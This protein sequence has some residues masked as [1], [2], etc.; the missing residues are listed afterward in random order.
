MH[1]VT[2]TGTAAGAAAFDAEFRRLFE[3]RF[4]SLFRYLDRLSG[5]AALAEDV[6]QQAF[7]KLYERGRMPDDP[8]AWLA[9][10][11]NNLFRDSR[12]GTSRRLR[13][14]SGRS[15]DFA[16]ADP[17][18]APDAGVDAPA[19]RQAARRALDGL[20]E[21]ERRMLLLR[22]E[23]YSY[24]EIAAALELAEASVGSLLLRARR[25]FKSAM[26]ETEHASA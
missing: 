2:R 4:A 7:V 18:P 24:R 5:D 20:P 11:A 19:R 17:P 22:V 26:E 9:A 14:L 12:R 13:L 16:L 10:V 23:G 25:A 15:P 21:R 8:P 1:P 6:A 3:A